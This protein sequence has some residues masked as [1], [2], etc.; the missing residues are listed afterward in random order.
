MS[1]TRAPQRVF[2]APRTPGAVSLIQRGCLKLY[3]S[4]KPGAVPSSGECLQAAL[5][6][7]GTVA[8]VLHV[9]EAHRDSPYSHN[10]VRSC[11]YY[12]LKAAVSERLS[13]AELFSVAGFDRFWDHLVS[14]VPSMSANSAV[15][16]LY[17]CAQ[18]D[19][20]HQTLSASLVDVCTQK[21]RHIP[22][23]SIGILLWSLKRLD[24][25]SSPST[26]PLLTHLVDLFHSR[27]ASGEVVFKTQSLSNILW[28]LAS[29]N[30]LPA[31]LGE[32]VTEVLPRYMDQF[33][34]HSLS[35]CLWSLTSSGA[36]LTQPLLDSAGTAAAGFLETERSVPNTIHCCWA[37]ASAEYYHRSFCEALSQAIL[38][39]RSSSPMLT[40]RLLSSV[41]WMCAKV[42]YFNPTLLDCIA[43]RALSELRQFN[44][45]DLGNL[46]YAYAQLDY[47]HQQLVSE[48]TRRFVS[49]KRLLSDDGACVSVAWANLAIGEYPLP[50]LEHLMEPS[51]VRRE[52]ILFISNSTY[53]IVATKAEI[54]KLFLLLFSSGTI[55]YT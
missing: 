35:L 46:M 29:S 11:L 32:R 24:L 42:G 21:S 7:T 31:H 22:S 53:T 52:L 1:A 50:L 33:D 36:T 18:F 19:F 20:H 45:Q 2:L 48:V 23:V 47:P 12:S 30:N 34:F 41:A 25:L 37:F 4:T 14:Q 51:R 26:Q 17:N 43:S 10:L 49:D 39:E 40:P 28:V 16:C 44:A 38:T 15:K 9:W 55:N 27:L 8:E 13:T 6:S 3:L 54:Y 5:A